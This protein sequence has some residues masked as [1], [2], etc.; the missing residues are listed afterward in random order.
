[1]KC[2][3]TEILSRFSQTEHLCCLH[4]VKRQNT[5]RL[6]E[7]SDFPPGDAASLD[8]SDFLTFVSIPWGMPLMLWDLLGHLAQVVC[9]LWNPSCKTELGHWAEGLGIVLQPSV[10]SGLE[11]VILQ[12]LPTPP[13][14]VLY[15][16]TSQASLPWP[17][18]SV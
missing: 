1:M 10:P 2:D 4:Q 7:A 13:T 17:G 16:L 8:P 18:L 9:P 5:A 3:S 14:H 12:A 15:P 11:S 6:P